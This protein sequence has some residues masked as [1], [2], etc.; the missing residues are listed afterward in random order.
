MGCNFC[1]FRY[2]NAVTA[3]PCKMVM[4]ES[5]AAVDT[6]SAT[7]ANSCREEASQMFNSTPAAATVA[8]KVSQRVET[9]LLPRPLLKGGDNSC[10]AS[11]ANC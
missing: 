5:A 3:Q 11:D 10:K 1:N 4:D 2:C 8:A 9:L 6:K 7:N